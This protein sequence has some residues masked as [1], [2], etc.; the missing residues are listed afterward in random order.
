MLDQQPCVSKGSSKDTKE[1]EV[2]PPA[3]ILSP[4][5]PP[6][7]VPRLSTCATQTPPRQLKVPFSNLDEDDDESWTS[8]RVTPKKS[9]GKS[10]GRRT[11]PSPA[12]S[13]KSSLVTEFDS[14]K[15]FCPICQMPLACVKITKF[16]HTVVCE[17]PEDSPGNLK[18]NY[19]CVSHYLILQNARTN[20][21]AST[22]VVSIFVTINTHF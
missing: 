11:G 12:K 18:L 8:A 19:F 20:W 17:V 3:K 10:P 9:K 1:S 13:S 2:S 22:R 7:K 16:A 5:Q 4:K 15:G 14:S 21:I 6:T